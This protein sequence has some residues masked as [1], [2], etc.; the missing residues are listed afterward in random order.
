[1]FTI[2]GYKA[3]NITKIKKLKI[4]LLV[5]NELIDIFCSLKTLFLNGRL[6]TVIYP[7]YNNNNNPIMVGK[8]L[9][10]VT[11]FSPIRTFGKVREY[12]TIK[13]P[14]IER[15]TP[16]EILSKDICKFFFILNSHN[17]KMPRLHGAFYHFYDSFVYPPNSSIV[18]QVWSCSLANFSNSSEFIILIPKPL[19]FIKS[20]NSS[21][22]ATS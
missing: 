19:F 2:A 18:F 13:T 7:P 8:K 11:I 21:V 17:L 12:K 14:R 4:S 10:P 16:S 1:M 9:G 5:K 15:N 3:I 6:V 22:C 20:L